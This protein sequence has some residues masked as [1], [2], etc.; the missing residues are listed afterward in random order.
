[1]ASKTDDV[2]AAKKQNAAAL[3][4]SATALSQTAEQ[5]QGAGFQIMT[6]STQTSE[7]IGAATTLTTQRLTLLQQ[8]LQITKQ[9]NAAAATATSLIAPIRALQAEISAS[10]QATPAQQ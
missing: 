3:T 1:I 5:V 10:K 2:V 4:T 7:S 9:A 6:L 8:T